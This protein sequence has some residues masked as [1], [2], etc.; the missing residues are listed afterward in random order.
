MFHMV[1]LSFNGIRM[2]SDKTAVAAITKSRT[3]KKR[4]R[5]KSYK[6]AGSFIVMG[7]FFKNRCGFGT[8]SDARNYFPI[9]FS[10]V[11]TASSGLVQGL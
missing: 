3:M 4:G 10:G 9:F 1:V 5:Y 2:H 11:H 8:S 7:R 6:T